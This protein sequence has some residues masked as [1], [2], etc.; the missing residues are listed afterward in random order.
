[1]HKLNLKFCGKIRH[2]WVFFFFFNKFTF[3]LKKR[4]NPTRMKSSFYR[5][6]CFFFSNVAK[7]KS[8]FRKGI[9]LR[10][11]FFFRETKGGL[12][13]E[14]YKEQHNMK[15][16]YE[17]DVFSFFLSDWL[18]FFPSKEISLYSGIYLFFFPL[19]LLQRVARILTGACQGAARAGGA[20]RRHLWHGDYC[21]FKRQR[22]SLSR[23]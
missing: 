10:K 19:P 18:F 3:I 2:F 11:Y 15:V 12:F 14:H 21:A 16:I 13:W 17:N 7:L 9:I 1:M 4:H 5:L 23:I 22:L 20:E 6:R 8:P